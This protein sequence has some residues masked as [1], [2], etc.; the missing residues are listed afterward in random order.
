M[1][2]KNG[3]FW[4]KLFLCLWMSV[5]NVY[6]RNIFILWCIFYDVYCVLRGIIVISKRG[7]DNFDYLLYEKYKSKKWIG[8]GWVL[9]SKSFRVLGYVIG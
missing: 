7:V 2:L 3:K 6:L 1:F 8:N 4:K 5:L 9:L